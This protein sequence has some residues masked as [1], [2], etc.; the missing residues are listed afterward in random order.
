MNASLKV[1]CELRLWTLTWR[2]DG[3]VYWLSLAASEKDGPR[4]GC[5]NTCS[6]QTDTREEPRR[7]PNPLWRAGH[8][9]PLTL[10]TVGAARRGGSAPV[11]HDMAPWCF[12]QQ[13][14][15]KWRATAKLIEIEN[16]GWSPVSFPNHKQCKRWSE[17][18]PHV[19][20]VA[21]S[22]IC[23]CGAQ[24]RHCLTYINILY[25]LLIT[26]NNINSIL[27]SR[28]KFLF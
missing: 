26:T 22:A 27:L 11:P 8:C 23:Y 6:Q 2:Q 10:F 25:S 14:T 19:R 15:V 12:F 5:E 13:W 18:S 1:P 20:G 3:G 24:T 16:P 7:A 4:T 17:S 28:F 21:D 9:L